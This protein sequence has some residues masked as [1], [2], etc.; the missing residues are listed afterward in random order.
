MR[1]LATCFALACM[2]N[3]HLS[4]RLLPLA[5]HSEVSVLITLFVSLHRSAASDRWLLLVRQPIEHSHDFVFLAN[6]YVVQPKRFPLRYSHGFRNQRGPLSA[7]R[8]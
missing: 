7:R 8:Q 4:R 1:C 5:T 2:L 6:G 3:N